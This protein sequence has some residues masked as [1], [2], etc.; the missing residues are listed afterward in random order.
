MMRAAGL[1]FGVGTHLL[2]AVTVWQLVWFLA[3]FSNSRSGDSD[4]HA[5][6]VDAG[7]ALQFAISHSALLHPTVRGWLGRWIAAPFYGL[8]YCVATCL[9]LLWLFSCWQA[10]PSVVWAFQGSTALVIQIGFACCWIGLLHSLSLTGLGWQ[11]GLTPWWA[12]VRGLPAPRREFRPRSSY[13]LLRHPVYLSFLGLIWLTPVVTI[14]RAALIALWTVYIFIGSWL[15]DR[16]LEYYLGKTY[17]EYESRVAGYPFIPLGPLARI[18][19]P[20]PAR[21]PENSPV[22]LSFRQPEPSTPHPNRANGI[23]RAA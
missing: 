11:T 14:D 13:L 10:S 4:W 19:I 6:A 16:R 3:G 18:P 21:E 2:F 7:L 22:T 5:L 23:R 1:L 12:W 15:K 17:R 20:D 9:S 8:F